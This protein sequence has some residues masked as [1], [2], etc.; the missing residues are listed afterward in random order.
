[1]T[2]KLCG[3]L[4]KLPSDFA[5]EG[6][7]TNVP[8]FSEKLLN[9]LKLKAAN[10]EFKKGIELIGLGVRNG[11]MEINPTTYS[12]S[13][14]RN[15]AVVIE[16]IKYLLTAKALD[17]LSCCILPTY[18]NQKKSYIDDIIMDSS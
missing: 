7:M 17:G 16:L 13:N 14:A 1:L 4:S 9:W 12:R 8:L 5:Y 2:S 6:E 3:R 15:V 11:E 18:A 10:V